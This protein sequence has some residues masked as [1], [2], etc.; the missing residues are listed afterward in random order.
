[1]LLFCANDKKAA[2]KKSCLKK[3]ISQSIFLE[4]FYWLQKK[5]EQNHLRFFGI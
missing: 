5:L 4:K 2:V 3:A 1:M